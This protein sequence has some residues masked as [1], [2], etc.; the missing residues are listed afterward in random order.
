VLLLDKTRLRRKGVRAGQDSLSVEF[1]VAAQFVVDSDA[2]KLLHAIRIPLATHF[3]ESLLAGR[4]A[5]QGPQPDL[6]E[7]TL[8]VQPTRDPASFGND[9]GAMA[10]RWLLLKITGSPARARTRI[11]PNGFGGRSFMINRQLG[12]GRDFQSVVG[13]AAEVIDEALRGWAQRAAPAAGDGAATPA[14]AIQVR[15]ELPQF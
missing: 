2:R 6:S 11:K 12:A 15:G 4:R 8:A 13:R 5:D 14:R 1:V 7:A 9:T 3:S 10:Q